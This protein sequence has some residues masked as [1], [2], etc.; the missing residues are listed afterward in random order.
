[1]QQAFEQHWGHFCSAIVFKL[2]F[3]LVYLCVMLFVFV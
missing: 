2:L 3:L 1:M